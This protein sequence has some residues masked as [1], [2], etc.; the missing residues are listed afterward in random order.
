MWNFL[1]NEKIILAS[2]SPRRRELL[3][4]TGLK[5][6]CKP[7]E[8]EEDLKGLPP[9]ETAMELSRKKAL[10]A[11]ENVTEGW[12]I[13]ADTIVLVDGQILGKPVD[14]K[15]AEWMLRLLSGT[16]HHVITGFTILH[17]PDK[18]VIS[19]Y[20]TTNVTFYNLSERDISDYIATTEP[21]DKAGAYGA[22]G[23]GAFLI[24]KIE[25]DFFNVVGLPLGKLRRVWLQM[26]HSQKSKV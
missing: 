7:V 2:N 9:E 1:H 18:A 25:G 11:A 20:E 15:D 3:R 21:F 4:E 14:A 24:E 12:I 8:I 16:T 26:I 13:S 6:V 17:L 22:Q 5:F 10:S 19:D 23:Y